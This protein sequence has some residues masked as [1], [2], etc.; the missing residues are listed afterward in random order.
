MPSPFPALFNP[1]HRKRG[2]MIWLII[3][4]STMNCDSFEEGAVV[5]TYCA[6]QRWRADRNKEGWQKVTSCIISSII[7]ANGM[8]F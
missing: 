5:I 4:S 8:V 1:L 7:V 6:E 3:S 2:N